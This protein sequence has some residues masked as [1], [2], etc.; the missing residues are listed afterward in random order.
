MPAPAC[1]GCCCYTARR[2]WAKSP[3]RT[4]GLLD[5]HLV[6]VASTLIHTCTHTQAHMYTRSKCRSGGDAD[7]EEGERVGPSGRGS[8]GQ[9]AAGA[10]RSKKGVEAERG[11][12]DEEEDRYQG[13]RGAEGCVLGKCVCGQQLKWGQCT[14]GVDMAG[15]AEGCGSTHWGV[16]WG[17]AALF[18]G[19]VGVRQHSFWGA[20]GV[21]PP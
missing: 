4:H 17:V 14:A 1:V 8:R 21:W 6:K 3:A 13:A 7:V 11:E 18:G 16:L 19:G 5:A 10:G 15:H 20:V 12:D 9:P 2:C